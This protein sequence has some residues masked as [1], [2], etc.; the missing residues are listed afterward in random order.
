MTLTGIPIGEVVSISTSSSEQGAIRAD[1]KLDTRYPVAQSS[2]LRLL[3]SGIFGD[4]YLEFG[5][6]DR[7][8]PEGT[9]AMDGNAAV[10]VTPGL[11]DEVTS[12]GKGI[13]AGVADVLSPANRKHITA[14]LANLASATGRMDH[15]LDRIDALAGRLDGMSAA[16]TD[17]VGELR[18]ETATLSASLQESLA[19]LDA[20]LAIWEERSDPISAGLQ[21]GIE[22]GTASLVRID[23]LVQRGD[24]MLAQ[25][26]DAI[27]G[28]TSSLRQSLERADALLVDLEQGRGVLGMLL[29]NDV[30]AQDLSDTMV[31]VKDLSE[32]TADHPEI[33]VWGQS[34]E[35]R[36]AQQRR[37][38]LMRAR[39]SFNA[40]QR[41]RSAFEPEG[42]APV[43]MPE[44]EG[45]AAPLPGQPPPS[46]EDPAAAG[47]D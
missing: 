18:S 30:L 31:N 6:P 41:G 13:L 12:Q 40:G 3:T 15:T 37:R 45:L 7:K 23:A 10:Q 24:R 19:G 35:E 26:A 5:P 44:K 47:A 38:E 17:L 1:L 9:L 33:L 14:T 20:V 22:Q 11:F 34:E 28:V 25:N 36:A 21:D 29:R 16:G 8:Q 39:R 46:Q 27:A 43:P 42:D 32:R 4:S 2:E